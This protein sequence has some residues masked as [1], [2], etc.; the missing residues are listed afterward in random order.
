MLFTIMVCLTVGLASNASVP[1]E[2]RN[3]NFDAPPDDEFRS[4]SFLD[5]FKVE[6]RIRVMIS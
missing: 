6:A 3:F 4:L 1:V 2:A 5:S